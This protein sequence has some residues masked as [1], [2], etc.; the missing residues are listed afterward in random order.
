MEMSDSEH[1]EEEDEVQDDNQIIEEEVSSV[2]AEEDEGNDGS[3][4]KTAKDEADK[5]TVKKVTNQ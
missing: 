2:A 5:I 4:I 1:I 3:K